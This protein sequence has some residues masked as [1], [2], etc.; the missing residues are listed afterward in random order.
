MTGT[1]S[2][3]L[4]GPTPVLRV[5]RGRPTEEELAAVA[6]VLT[7]VAAARNSP[8]APGGSGPDSG[9]RRPVPWHTSGSPR[10]WVTRQSGPAGDRVPRAR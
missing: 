5:V 2:P 10:S 8:S 1:E 9:V 7:S 6:A 3:A 4:P